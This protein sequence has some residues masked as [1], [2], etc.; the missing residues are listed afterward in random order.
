MILS[1]VN[2]RSR[3][4]GQVHEGHEGYRM[5][6]LRRKLNMQLLQHATMT[7]LSIQRRG[8]ALTLVIAPTSQPL[9]FTFHLEEANEPSQA[10][11]AKQQVVY[12]ISNRL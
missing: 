11:D 5:K 9:A 7:N 6:I 8:L 1:K 12:D 3:R 4:R 2:T 10:T